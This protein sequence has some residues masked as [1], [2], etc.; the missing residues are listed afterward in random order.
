MKWCVI[1]LLVTLPL[2]A[3]T[4][5]VTYNLGTSSLSQACGSEQSC[6]PIVFNLPQFSGPG[7]L[8]AVEWSL[9]DDVQYYG[10]INDMYQTPGSPWSATFVVGDSSTILGLDA[11]TGYSES[12][13][14]W[15]YGTQISMGGW[16]TSDLIAASGSAADL[17]PFLGDGSL[18][19]AITPFAN[20][21]ASGAAYA[22]ILE[23]RDSISLSV[24][25]VDPVVPEPR[26]DAFVV[27]ALVG[28]AFVFNNRRRSRA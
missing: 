13:V 24:T 27:I 10:G 5:T 28:V 25:Y 14:V 17:T 22:G 18:Q 1:A 20:T 9:T 3:D 6:S 23:M 7:T 8:T 12:G 16:W 4:I 2:S 11:T 15:G 21:T 26:W 19:L